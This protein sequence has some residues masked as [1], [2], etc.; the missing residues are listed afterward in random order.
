MN[1]LLR[2]ATMDDLETILHHRQE[3]FREMGMTEP[4][5]VAASMALSREFFRKALHDGHYQGWLFEEPETHEIAAGGGIILIEY[6]PSPMDPRPRRPW[7]VNV[8]THPRWRKQGLARKLM[9]EMIDWS[10]AAGFGRL[11]LHASNE[12]RPLYESLGFA[13]TNEM[14][15]EL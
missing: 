4:V 7:V 8:Y 11:Y 14:L 6:H 9:A 12:G 10:R 13:Q 3:M 1:L 2:K 15:L 5:A